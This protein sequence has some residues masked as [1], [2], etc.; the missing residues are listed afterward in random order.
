ME[1]ATKLFTLWHVLRERG[2]KKN[3]SGRGCSLDAL[4]FEPLSF[5]QRSLSHNL[6]T[7]RSKNFVYI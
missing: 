1:E 6:C 5:S 7:G 4:N 2:L 3:K